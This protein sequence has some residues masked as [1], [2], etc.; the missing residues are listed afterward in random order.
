MISVSAV[1]RA[2]YAFGVTMET[3][4][5]VVPAGMAQHLC[6]LASVAE[7]GAIGVVGQRQR[8]PFVIEA[9]VADFLWFFTYAHGFFMIFNGFVAECQIFC[10]FAVLSV[11]QGTGLSVKPIQRPHL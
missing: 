11:W 8:T 4:G 7:L 6:A 5:S 10:I 3:T 2:V 1:E 9:Q